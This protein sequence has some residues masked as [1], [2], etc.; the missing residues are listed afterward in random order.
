MVH[1]VPTCR[2]PLRPLRTAQ[3]QMPHFGFPLPLQVLARRHSQILL[4]QRRCSPAIRRVVPLHRPKARTQV[5]GG[6][7][8]L[9]WSPFS[10]ASWASSARLF[11]RGR[12]A[13]RS[14]SRA[15]HRELSEI[16]EPRHF[17]PLCHA[18]DGGPGRSA[19]RCPHWT[20]SVP[21]WALPHFDL[22]SSSG[23]PHQ[24]HSFPSLD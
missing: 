19:L 20:I 11:P 12:D 24:C 3:H 14:P 16:V 18:S 15:A 4:S 1:L 7:T 22:S 2:P 17:A 8:R 21:E 10:F 6:H 5:Q 23:K 13:R 9:S